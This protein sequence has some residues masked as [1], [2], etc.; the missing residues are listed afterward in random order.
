MNIWTSDIKV[1]LLVD[2]NQI[3][4]SQG[5]EIKQFDIRSD[6]VIITSDSINKL[7]NINSVDDKI[8][9]TITSISFSSIDDVRNYY[10]NYNFS[11]RFAEIHVYLMI[12]IMIGIIF[13]I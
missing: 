1:N 13:T 7:F 11:L 10:I 9:E 8:D 4:F 2:T 3:N 6:K 5:K 12:K